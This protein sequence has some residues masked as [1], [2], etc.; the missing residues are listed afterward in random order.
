MTSTSRWLDRLERVGNRLPDPSLLFVACTLLAFAASAVLAGRP[1]GITDART[2][3]ELR[4]VDQCTVDGVLAFATGLVRNFIAFPPLGM[5][6]VAMLGLGVADHSGFISTVLKGLLGLTPRKLLTPIVIAA[7]ILSHSAVDAGFVLVI[8]LAALVFAAAGRH[9]LAGLAAGFAG[10]S[11]GLSANPI[12][13]SLDALVQGITQSAAAVI[14]PART[15]NPLCNWYFNGAA[16]VLILLVGW[17]VTD[18]LVEPRARRVPVDGQAERLEL[19]ALAPNELR[20][21]SWAFGVLLAVA[22]SLVVA[23]WSPTSAL[24]NAAGSLSAHD[25]PLMQ[26]IVPLLFVAGLASGLAFGFA[27]GRYRSQHDLMTGLSKSMEGMASYLVMAFFAAQFIAV[28]TQANLGAWIATRGANGLRAL[29]LAPQPTVLGVILI[30][31][32]VDVLIGSCSAK[33]ALLAPVMVPMGMQLGLS[34]ELVQGAYRIG[35]STTNIVTPLMP[36]FPLVV[37]YCQRHCKTCGI[38][39]L[40]ALML[41]YS[42]AFLALWSGL[43]LAFWGLGVP[44]GPGSPYAYP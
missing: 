41:P 6:L 17:W 24:R 10:V 38:G 23:C 33:W 14:D 20:G 31:A 34:P 39:T 5:V 9:P 44:L 3:A 11:G 40:V 12:P 29:D 8:P 42:I 4:V 19:G 2:G 30:S 13:S 21:L 36:Y 37:T 27:S 26:L 32:L 18:V 1:T 15:V 43:L 22:G 35:D 28:F 7:G 25:A 16:S